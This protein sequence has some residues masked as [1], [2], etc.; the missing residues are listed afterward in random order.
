MHTESH[1]RII[2]LL[3]ALAATLVLAGCTKDGF[4]LGRKGS[5]EVP[6]VSTNRQVGFAGFDAPEA[7][8]GNAVVTRGERA[9]ALDDPIAAE[10][11]FRSA[12]IRGDNA[13]APEAGDAIPEGPVAGER[14]PRRRFILDPLL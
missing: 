3:A 4:R 9:P 2:V 7:G 10:A 13:D 12:D 11:R 8:E 6:G 14:A 1:V 5:L